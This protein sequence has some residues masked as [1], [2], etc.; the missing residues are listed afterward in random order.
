MER[1]RKV[2]DE[3]LEETEISFGLR[4]LKKCKQLNQ[5]QY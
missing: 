2:D 4:Y 5:Q 1:E 3:I